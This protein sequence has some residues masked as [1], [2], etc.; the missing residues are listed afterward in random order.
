MF[1]VLRYY[2]QPKE[3]ELQMHT[4]AKR[5]VSLFTISLTFMLVLFGC[6]ESAGPVR[7]QQID[8]G[9]SFPSTRERWPRAT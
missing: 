4:I 5:A 8:Q 7:D 6:S 1:Q 2:Y 9:P 3:R